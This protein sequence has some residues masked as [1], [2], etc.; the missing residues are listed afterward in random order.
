M[1]K[2][3][4]KINK[5]IQRILYLLVED[6]QIYSY[7][8]IFIVVILC[9]GGLYYLLTPYGNG[10]GNDGKALENLSFLNAV[11]FSVVTVSSLGYGDMHPMGFS[12]FL[13][14][15][16]V[17]FGLGIMGIM[18]AKL[19]STRISYHVSRLYRSELQKRLE[20]FSS[21][22]EKIENELSTCMRK[23]GE[24]FQ[25][26]PEGGNNADSSMAVK[27]CSLLLSRFSS[28]TLDLSEYITEET[29]KGAFFEVAPR[30]T[31][32]KT[33]DAIDQ[34]LFNLAQLVTSLSPEAKTIV[35]NK[36]NRKQ[37]SLVV[38]TV[39]KI[40][41]FSLENCK[42]TELKSTFLQMIQNCSKIPES[43]YS[44]PE[45]EF[46][47]QPDQQFMNDDEP[48]STTGADL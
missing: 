11:Y 23:L 32:Q 41:E 8:Y 43:Y 9:L 35:L 45:L 1:T 13:A 17:L 19:T 3:L 40:A 24:A 16:E 12:K 39:Q 33:T 44:T 18:V 42:H 25:N 36:N 27:S 22:F 5:K 38:E 10:I 48:Q 30:K 29:N 21:D 26:T 47:S 46:N 4:Q 7:V 37:T 20:E 31:L 6:V 14:I 15:C 2:F 34:S 28:R